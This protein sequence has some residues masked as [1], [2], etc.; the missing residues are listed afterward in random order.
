LQPPQPP[1]TGWSPKSSHNPPRV[2]GF[3][4][5]GAAL[6]SLALGAILGVWLSARA[7]NQEGNASA[8]PLYTRDL[9]DEAGQG[10]AL[11]TSAYVFLGV[12]IALAVTDVVLWYEI[13]RKPRVIK[14][15]PE[16]V[17]DLVPQ[18]QSVTAR[19]IPTP[20]KT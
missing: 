7:G 16:G 9:R 2:Y 4:F 12:G 18:D 20:R 8:P 14:R 15:T 13:Y 3:A 10:R 19:A 1:T 5:G 17:V 6:G 11:A